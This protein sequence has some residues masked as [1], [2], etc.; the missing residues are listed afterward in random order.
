MKFRDED[1]LPERL[2]RPL[3]LVNLKAAWLQAADQADRLFARLP[4]AEVGC[5]YLAPSL[6]PTTPDPA[7]TDFPSTTRH[8]GSLGGAWPRGVITQ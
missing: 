6:T 5:L 1:L 3:S 8:Y 2:E 7:G 4:I